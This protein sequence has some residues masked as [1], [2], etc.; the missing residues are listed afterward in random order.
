[1]GKL[2]GNL[3]HSAREWRGAMAVAVLLLD[4]ALTVII[5]AKVD[6]ALPSSQGTLD[7]DRSRGPAN[8]AKRPG[9]QGATAMIDWIA[10]MEEVQGFLAGEKNYSL[11]R[12]TTGPLVYPGGSLIF[13]RSRAPAHSARTLRNRPA[14]RLCMDI[15]RIVLALR[16]GKGHCA[17]SNYIHFRVSRHAGMRRRQRQPC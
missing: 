8:R 5:V 9:K 13:H 11:L 16:R 4:A 15:L 7:R 17:G 1:M 14:C 6:T 10:Y 3:V 12:G 2:V